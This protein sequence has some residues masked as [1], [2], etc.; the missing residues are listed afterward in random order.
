MSC[1]TMADDR[2]FRPSDD[3][4][5]ALVVSTTLSVAGCALV[6]FTYV[7]WRRLRRHPASLVVM[8]SLLDLLL[9]VEMLANRLY[10]RS[11]SE[12]AEVDDCMAFSVLSQFLAVAAE[13]F[14]LM[15]SFDLYRSISNPFTNYKSNMRL[16]HVLTWTVSAVT[17]SMLLVIKEPDGRPIYG[18]DNVLDICWIRRGAS[19][20][21]SDL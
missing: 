9:C 3:V 13:L 8:R 1:A 5:L 20:D 15:L 14:S 16:Y 21:S 7:R 11:E 18:R 2:V 6:I 10:H 12:G 19:R 17:A 4:T